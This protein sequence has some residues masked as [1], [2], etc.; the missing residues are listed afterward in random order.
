[1][2]QCPRR[3]GGRRHSHGKVLHWST[4]IMVGHDDLVGNE[5]EDGLEVGVKN[6]SIGITP[7]HFTYLS[8]DNNHDN[9]I[10]N[11]LVE[12]PSSPWTSNE[13]VSPIAGDMTLSFYD[14]G[15]LPPC[16]DPLHYGLTSFLHWCNLM[17]IHLFILHINHSLPPQLHPHASLAMGARS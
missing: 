8:S 10:I 12:V 13:T 1:M 6:N 9:L 5:K 15:N 11:S 17:L 16:S 3:L 14:M 2:A 7:C 4:S